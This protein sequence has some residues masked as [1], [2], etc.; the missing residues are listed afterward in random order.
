MYSCSHVP[1]DTS[2]ESLGTIQS[3]SRTLFIMLRRAPTGSG[4]LSYYISSGMS[5]GRP[6]PSLWSTSSPTMVKWYRHR[7]QVLITRLM[8]RR[9]GRTLQMF[10]QVAVS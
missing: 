6:V 4:T 2:D 7:L 3:I 8:Q 1:A 9:E 5:C 10:K